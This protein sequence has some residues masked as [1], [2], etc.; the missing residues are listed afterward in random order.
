MTKRKGPAKTDDMQTRVR[1]KIRTSGLN[2][3]QV[4]IAKGSRVYT[5]ETM[6]DFPRTPV[7]C[8]DEDM[9]IKGFRGYILSRKQHCWTTPMETQLIPTT[10]QPSEPINER[11]CSKWLID[12]KVDN[13]LTARLLEINLEN[14]L[15]YDF[16]DMIVQEVLRAYLEVEKEMKQEREQEVGVGQERSPKREIEYDLDI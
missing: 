4:D 5:R 16:L 11:N 14:D 2:K 10:T 6:P 13:R 15:D 9:K 7:L 3:E 12:L 1:R 8:M